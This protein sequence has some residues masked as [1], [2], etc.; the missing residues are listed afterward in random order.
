MLRNYLGLIRKFYTNTS[1]PAALILSTYFKL[2]QL[3]VISNEIS[4]NQGYALNFI[5]KYIDVLMCEKLNV[6]IHKINADLNF[7]ITF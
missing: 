1:L 2:R 3:R 6:V 7:K 4:K 5:S